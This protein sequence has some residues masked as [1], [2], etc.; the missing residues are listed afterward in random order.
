MSEIS[1]FR[2]R[3]RK[4]KLPAFLLN[5]YVFTSFVFIVWMLFF[6]QNNLFVQMER[7][8]TLQDTRNK[9]EYYAEATDMTKLELEALLT[10]EE[11]LERFA[12]EQYFMKK[13]NEDV[14]VIIEE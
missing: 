2:K 10:N 13:P 12:R 3:V 14:F 1:N 7:Y 9:M 6:D 4:W 11:T 8:Q 5:R